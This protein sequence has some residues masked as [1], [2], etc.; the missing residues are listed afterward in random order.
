MG[1]RKILITGG[2]GNLGLWITEYLSK[3]D[4]EIYVLSTRS[5]LDS[6]LIEKNFQVISGDIRDF[7]N[8]QLSIPSEIDY[9]IHL[10]SFN[11]YFLPDYPT[12]ALEINRSKSG[13]YSFLESNWIPILF[14]ITTLCIFISYRFKR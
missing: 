13:A 7:A 9:I 14:L 3:Q 10:A 12:K 8:L 5:N 6:I 4:Y 2:L 11:D 1:G